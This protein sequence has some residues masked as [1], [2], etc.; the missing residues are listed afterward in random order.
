M[1]GYLVEEVLDLM[2]RQVQGGFNLR[3]VL[4]L[5]AQGTED[6]CLQGRQRCRQVAQ[7]VG[8]GKGRQQ[9][10]YEMVV[11]QIIGVGLQQQIHCDFWKCCQS[12]RE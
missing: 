8:L 12:T 3:D 9:V 11:H 6:G 4:L 1:K 2:P 5:E 10:Q 7:E